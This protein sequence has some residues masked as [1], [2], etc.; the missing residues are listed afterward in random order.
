MRSRKARSQMRRRDK[1]NMLLVQSQIGLDRMGHTQIQLK[2]TRSVV[3]Q[4][5][6]HARQTE[7]VATLKG[8]SPLVLPL[9]FV[10]DTCY[11]R[12]ARHLGTQLLWVLFR[13]E[14]DSYH[15]IRRPVRHPIWKP[16]P[17]RGK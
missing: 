3:G 5:Y 1:W 16:N 11:K 4:T 6:H 2:K 10:W 9:D 8:Q 15:A 7:T 17:R 12:P 13:N 14:A